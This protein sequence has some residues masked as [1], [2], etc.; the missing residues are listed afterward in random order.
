[1]VTTTY[2]PRPDLN[3]NEATYRIEISKAYMT[4]F[5]GESARPRLTV[6]IVHP[7]ADD[8][9]D[10]ERNMFWKKAERIAKH[11]KKDLFGRQRVEFDWLM[12]LPEHDAIQPS[13]GQR[14][15]VPPEKVSTI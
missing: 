9:W 1:M 10:F 6:V 13:L 15:E 12:R 2:M 4:S 7:Y 11:Y 14:I 8:M 5:F 3:A